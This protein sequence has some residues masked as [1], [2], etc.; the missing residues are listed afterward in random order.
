MEAQS[1]SSIL[2]SVSTGSTESTATQTLGKDAFL[3]LLIT[4]LKNQNPLEPLDDQE[5]IA[6]M[7]QFS[8]LE[9]LQNMNESLSENNQWDMLMSQTINNTMATS[10]IGREVTASTPAVTINDGE[11]SP[12]T[13]D[14]TEFTADGTITIYDS[15]GTPVRTL[16]VSLLP[17]GENSVPW[18]GKDDD[19]NKLS[20]GSY[21]F[22]TDLYGTDGES[23]T[24][25]SYLKGTVTAV[26]YIQGQA[27]LEVDG[28]MIPL[29]DVTKIG[30][31]EG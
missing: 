12:I 28:A 4:Q 3:E 23:V 1:V 5:F 17:A 16:H 15:S 20:D 26:K 18:D 7:T 25:E 29:S 22:Q 13:F 6:Q 8:S 19:G 21:T 10:L 31:E 27:Y 9:Q 30:L 24:S 2:N 14:T 11:A